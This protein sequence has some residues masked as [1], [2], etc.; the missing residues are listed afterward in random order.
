MLDK[1]IVMI[2]GK[3]RY[4]FD[5]KVPK[6]VDGFGSEGDRWQCRVRGGGVVIYI[7]SS[8]A[9][10]SFLMALNKVIDREI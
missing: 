5:F 1:D 8:T 9:R 10:S 3:S 4:R 7:T 6:H 2:V